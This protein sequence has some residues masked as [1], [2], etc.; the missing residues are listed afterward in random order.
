MIHKLEPHTTN[1]P[2]WNAG[3]ECRKHWRV[4]CLTSAITL[5][6]TLIIL[7]SIPAS[8]SAQ[9]SIADEKKEN[10]ILIGLKTWEGWLNNSNPLSKAEVDMNDI[11]VYSQYIDSYDFWEEV[12]HVAI[13]GNK[14][15][16]YSHI[17][18]KEKGKKRE[19]IIATIHDKIKYQVFS[20]YA[21]A[22]I[23]VTDENPYVAAVMA[24]SVASHLLFRMTKYRKKLAKT[25]LTDERR[26]YA[27]CR[28]NYA[29]IQTK[30]SLYVDNHQDVA[31]PSGQSKI[32]SL[33]KERD[34]AFKLLQ[35]AA[36]KYARAEAMAMQNIRSFSIVKSASVPL[37]PSA[38]NIGGYLSALMIINGIITTW[39]ILI[40]RKIKE[41]ARN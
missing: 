35:D 19:E 8:Y 23:Q 28:K 30:Y 11:L 31:E 9:V 7:Y 34:N 32:D 29:A 6:I 14:T 41:S 33:Q 40:R 20:R 18:K 10:G 38:P 24:D 39:G 26:E 16:Y 22:T 37:K 15:D 2:L 13:P 27:S 17:A 36:M 21:T 5:C 3:E 12:S 4:Y 25:A 1:K